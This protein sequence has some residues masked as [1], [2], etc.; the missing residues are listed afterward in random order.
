[1]TFLCLGSDETSTF[2][3]TEK[4]SIQKWFQSFA[5]RFRFSAHHFLNGIKKF[6]CDNR[7]MLAF[8]YFTTISHQASE[9]RVFQYLLIVG[10]G[11][12]LSIFPTQ[13]K[14]VKFVS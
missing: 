5:M 7:F 13:S 10:Y 9:Y 12:L 11:K 3:A 4:S 1:M 2:S 14:F 6:L 8:V